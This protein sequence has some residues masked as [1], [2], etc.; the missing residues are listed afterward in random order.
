MK[1]NNILLELYLQ[2]QIKQLPDVTPIFIKF[3]DHV[4]ILKLFFL[5][6]TRHNTLFYYYLENYQT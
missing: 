3:S 1:A 4:N 6:S 2:E 5:L